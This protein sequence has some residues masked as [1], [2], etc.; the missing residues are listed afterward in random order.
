MK[1]Q[2]LFILTTTLLLACS[3]GSELDQ[4]KEKLAELKKEQQSRAE[5]IQQLEKEVAAL[6]PNSQANV[7]VIPV[8]TASVS[9]QSFKHYI[10]VQ[11]TLDS[12]SNI[13]VTP[14]T[15]G[16][17][18]AVYVKEGDAVRKGQVL[19]TIDDAILRQSVNEVQTG[20]ELANTI[21]ERQ[22]N[23]WDQKIGSEVQYLQAKN[24]KESL[25][26]K[27]ETLQSQLA[28]N[29]ITSPINGVV[30]QVIVKVGE[31]AGPTAGAVRV[32]DPTD[33]RVVAK[34]ADTY[35]GSVR[36]GGAVNI[37]VP[38]LN[39]EIEGKIS[40]VGQVVNP[41]TRT[42]DVEVSVNNSDQQLKPN[43]L[44]LININDQTQSN[45]IVINENIVQKTAAG[46]LVFVAAEE[47]GKKVAKQRKVKTGLSYNGQVVI[48]EG[49]SAGEQLITDGFQDLVDGQPVQ[50]VV[51][52]K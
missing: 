31:G 13:M 34:V 27:L 50:M 15:A 17:V 38:D 30:D 21:Y 23:L 42:F 40:F 48:Q 45:A 29:K 47:G 49:L 44:V 39:R 43:M 8:K 12:R 33:I 22:K 46:D 1:S 3:K 36:K 18:T 51:A 6:Q 10:Q 7:R 35:M 37:S 5:E 11:G 9:P 28:Q 26:R 20:L 16:V 14:K 41:T 24:N 32:V 25:E 19:A 4:K 2:Y 52:E